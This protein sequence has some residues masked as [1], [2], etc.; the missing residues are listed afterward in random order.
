MPEDEDLEPVS[1][2]TP[3]RFPH[4]IDDEDSDSFG[5][6]SHVSDEQPF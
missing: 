1:D 6:H 3:S 2:V 4:M 5:I